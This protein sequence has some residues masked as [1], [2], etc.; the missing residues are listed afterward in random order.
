MISTRF[1]YFLACITTILIGL[2]SRRFSLIPLFIGDTLYA[3]MI[4]FLIRIIIPNKTKSLVAFL[5]L[6]F[7]F[8]I[9]FSQ[10][11][12]NYLLSI[13]RSYKLGKLVLGQGFLIED[14]IAYSIGIF[15]VYKFDKKFNN[16]NY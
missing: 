2:L 4:Y 8:T 1:K 16:L 5:A 13:A 6:I 14:L 10:L 11:S 12:T 7:C 9:E 15:I 3:V